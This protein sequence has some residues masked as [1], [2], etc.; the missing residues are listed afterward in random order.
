AV[1][2]RGGLHVHP[3]AEPVRHPG[4]LLAPRV[5]VEVEPGRPVHAVQPERLVRRGDGGRWL[6]DGG[7]RRG[8]AASGSPRGQ[9]RLRGPAAGRITRRSPTESSRRPIPPGTAG[10][11][12]RGRRSPGR[13]D[14]LVPV[15]DEDLVPAGGRR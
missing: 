6:V 2:L 1:A 7:P 15:E 11:V 13:R 14:R 8:G 10:A 12:I 5:A 9:V 4:L 3:F